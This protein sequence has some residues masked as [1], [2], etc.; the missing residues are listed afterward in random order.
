MAILKKDDLDLTSLLDR[1]NNTL[2]L[3]VGMRNTLTDPA[4]IEK[5]F[6]RHLV[7]GT[8]LSKADFDF[9]TSRVHKITILNLNI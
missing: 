7:D 3:P 4:D 5:F 8:A 2:F 1:P 6:R 9:G